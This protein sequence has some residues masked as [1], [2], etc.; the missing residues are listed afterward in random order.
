[1]RRPKIRETVKGP[2]AIIQDALIKFLELR[3]W[4]VKSTHGNEF[5]SGLP[6][7]YCLHEKHKQ[8]WIECKNPAAY[9]FTPAQ[10]KYF[11][12]LNKCVG[13]WILTAA[14]ESE[15]NKLFGPPNWWHY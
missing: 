14:T 1:M 8:R 10:L 13:V 7:L 5:Q 12:I 4:V 15:Y 2:E 11:P 9:V 6:D 3:G